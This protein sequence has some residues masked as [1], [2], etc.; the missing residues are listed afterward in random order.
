MNGAVSKFIGIVLIFFMALAM[1]GHAIL[2]EQV[3]M[4][5]SIVAEVT[6]LIDEVTDTGV[7]DDTRIADFYLGC[8][9]YGPLVDVEII[10]YVRIIN[11]KP[12]GGT[13]VS[14]VV[15]DDIT[16]WSEG[17]LIKVVVNEI[18]P[19]NFASFLYNI[20]SLSLSPIDF[21]LAGRV[22]V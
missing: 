8:A 11:P 17:D 5:R 7:L 20:C 3:L 21:S 4:R 1:F 12:G 18:G 10:R 16:N 2:S 19:T 22:R 6:N 9:S 15:S 14:Y 13:Y